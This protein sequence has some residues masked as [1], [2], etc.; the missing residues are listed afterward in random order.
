MKPASATIRQE[1]RYSH[2]TIGLHYSLNETWHMIQALD[3][4]QH[5]FN[6]Y[7]D[8]E[9]PEQA[10][11]FR[12]GVAKFTGKIVWHR[13]NED[14]AIICELMIN[15]ALFKQIKKL[16]TSLDT[17]HRIAN[18]IRT[19]GKIEEKKK[20]LA[21]AGTGFG[22]DDEIAARIAAYK[23]HHPSW[24]YGVRVDAAEW[25]HIVSVALET[26][27]VILA[28]EKVGQSLSGINA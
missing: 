25:S 7:S 5:G 8:C 18:L 4:N 10:L 23:Q 16:A 17:A 11:C 24:R 14:D 28:L 1:K 13:R 19:S 20:L 21:H 9:I 3:W 6:F 27:S 22:T 15:D 12:K 2:I 26:S